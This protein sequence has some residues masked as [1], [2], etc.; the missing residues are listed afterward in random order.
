[1]KDPEKLLATRCIART[2]QEVGRF[3]EAEVLALRI[4]GE[5]RLVCGDGHI[6]RASTLSVIDRTRYYLKNM[7]NLSRWRL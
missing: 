5:Q 3:A 2:L 1:M 7:P 6:S 4:D